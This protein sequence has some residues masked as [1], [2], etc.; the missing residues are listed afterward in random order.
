MG[1]NPNIPHLKVGYNP[2]TN[3]L[4][5]S[6]DIQAA[7]PIFQGIYRGPPLVMA[8]LHGSNVARMSRLSRLRTQKSKVRALTLIEWFQA[9]HA[10][11]RVGGWLDVPTI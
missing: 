10:L 8:N 7:K 3:H 2:F 5:T 1:Y 11:Q 6:W 4:L 9:K